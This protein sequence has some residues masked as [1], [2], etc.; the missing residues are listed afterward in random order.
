MGIFVTN[1]QTKADI[2]N[3]YFVEQCSTI[4][5]GSTLPRFLPKCNNVFETFPINR[6]Q[7]LK[8]IRSLDSKKAHG[9]DEISISMIKICDYLLVE[10]MC[11]IFEKCLVTGKYPSVWKKANVTPIH[12]KESRQSKKNYR[13]I[14]L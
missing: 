1:I 9:W 4:P 3:D 7:V 12:K 10:P 5:T 2:F 11:L 6:E 13:P 14:S 8:I